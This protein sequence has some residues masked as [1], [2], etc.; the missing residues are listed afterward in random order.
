MLIMI[1][2]VLSQIVFGG[3]TVLSGKSLP[4]NTAHVSTGAL[5]LAF[6]LSVAL[7]ACRSMFSDNELVPSAMVIGNA[8]SAKRKS[9]AVSSQDQH[10]FGL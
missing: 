9:P 8:Q 7:R 5:L 6:S 4:I 2:L 10:G 1:V 3:W